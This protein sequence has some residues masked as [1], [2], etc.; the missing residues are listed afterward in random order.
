M[1]VRIRIPVHVRKHALLVSE[2]A[3][4]VDQGGRYLLVVNAQNVVEQRTVTVGQLEDGMRV[5]KQGLQGDEWVVVNGIQRT[6]PGATVK[7]VRQEAPSGGSGGSSKAVKA[8]ASLAKHR[9]AENRQRLRGG[10]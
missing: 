5:I 10:K 4:G 9:A 8:R 6:R 1:F 2:R 3:L 7:P